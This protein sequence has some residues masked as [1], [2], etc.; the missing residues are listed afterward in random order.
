MTADLNRP[1]NVYV[2]NILGAVARRGPELEDGLENAR[3]MAVNQAQ[4][5]A[6]LNQWRRLSALLDQPDINEPVGWAIALPEES[7]RLTD[8]FLLESLVR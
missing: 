8:Q 1:Y 6:L 5:S 3:K 4:A 2:R 7:Q